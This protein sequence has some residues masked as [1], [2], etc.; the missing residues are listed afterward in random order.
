MS[1]R[2]KE[3]RYQFKRKGNE[4]QHVFNEEVKEAIDGALP[5]L[6]S[7]DTAERAKQLL[8]KG[9]DMLCERQKL[10]KIADRSDLGLLSDDR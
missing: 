9:S 4:L 2:L 3:E 7:P 8:R 10:I 1:Q 6:D 5:P